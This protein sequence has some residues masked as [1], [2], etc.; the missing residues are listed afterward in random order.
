MKFFERVERFWLAGMTS[1]PGSS[2]FTFVDP[3]SS[4][5]L[6]RYLDTNRKQERG[7]TRRDHAHAH[8]S[9]TP[10]AQPDDLLADEAS[11]I[12]VRVSAENAEALYREEPNDELDAAEGILLGCVISAYLW[13]LIA[14][15]LLGVL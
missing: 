14:R 9:D 7:H 6:T 13:L 12:T 3:M 8:R 10:P 15:Y 1:P 11:E 4:E 2:D 5:T